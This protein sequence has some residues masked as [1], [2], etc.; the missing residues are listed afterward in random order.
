M[1]PGAAIDE[2][3]KVGMGYWATILHYHTPLLSLPNLLA[4]T[5]NLSPP[6]VPPARFT[7]LQPSKD[8][9]L[10]HIFSSL[11]R[12]IRPDSD[13][14]MPL[15]F[16]FSLALSFPLLTLVNVLK[17]ILTTPNYKSKK[18]PYMGI[19]ASQKQ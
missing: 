16:T 13:Y 10:L 15:L 11:G 14:G 7:A 1:G 9:I 18:F 3:D 5:K 19:L 4:Q 8:S 6:Q 17:Y 12:R 2:S